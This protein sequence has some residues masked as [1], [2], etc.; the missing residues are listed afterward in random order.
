MLSKE[1]LTIVSVYLLALSITLIA[2]FLS[3][4]QIVR[5]LEITLQELT[6]ENNMLY[7]QLSKNRQHRYSDEE[8][9]NGD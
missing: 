1:S 3:V 8:K 6:D 7:A 9:T 2:G 5:R 4:A